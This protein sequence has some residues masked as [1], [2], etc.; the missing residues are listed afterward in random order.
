MGRA[1]SS[2]KLPGLLPVL[3]HSPFPLVPTWVSVWPL[4]LV[5]SGPSLDLTGSSHSLLPQRGPSCLS[6]EQTTEGYPV[7]QC[8][9]GDP[10]SAAAHSAMGSS[11]LRRSLG[12]V[13]SVAGKIQTH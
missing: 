11:A 7:R 9:P 3:P 5:P 8:C 12:G 2:L 6:P 13:Q 4:Q 10:Q 1:R